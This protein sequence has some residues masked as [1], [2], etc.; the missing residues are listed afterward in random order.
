MLKIG[1]F[2]KP[3][4]TIITFLQKI[5]HI[6]TKNC[7]FAQFLCYITFFLLTLTN[8]LKSYEGTI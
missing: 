2:C 4:I 1:H 3:D 7:T 8:I 5:L 6:S